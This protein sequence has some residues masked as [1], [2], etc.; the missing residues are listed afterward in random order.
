MLTPVPPPTVPFWLT[1]KVLGAN[2][3]VVCLGIAPHK[4]KSPVM[5]GKFPNIT[6]TTKTMCNGEPEGAFYTI[7]KAFGGYAP[8]GNNY[9]GFNASLSNPIYNNSDTVQ[10]QSAYTFIIIKV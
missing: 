7:N 6:G 4:A 1:E 5:L 3:P 2:G 8:G 10:P 9:I